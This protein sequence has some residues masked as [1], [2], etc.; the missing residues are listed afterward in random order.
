MHFRL[1]SEIVGYRFSGTVITAN[2][3]TRVI[4]LKVIAKYNIFL[5]VYHILGSQ[6]NSGMRDIVFVLL[7]CV[8]C[9]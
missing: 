2:S 9:F 6:C 4:L 3:W 8:V 5:Q 1:I 7:F